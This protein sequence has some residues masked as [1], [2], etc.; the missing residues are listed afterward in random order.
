M[1]SLLYRENRVFV[2]GPRHRASNNPQGF[3]NMGSFCHAR[4]APRFGGGGA[5]II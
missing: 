2:P 4:E 3:L 1:T 5:A